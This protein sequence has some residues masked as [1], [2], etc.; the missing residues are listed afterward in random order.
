[1][2]SS[3][4]DSEFWDTDASDDS[5][6]AEA[7]PGPAPLILDLPD[8]P[9]RRGLGFPG[10]TLDQPE[11][12]VKPSEADVDLAGLWGDHNLEV[13]DAPPSLPDAEPVRDP[14]PPVPTVDLGRP[15]ADTGPQRSGPLVVD[16]PP[17][18]PSVSDVADR[19]APLVLDLPSARSGAVADR[20]A[21]MVM[22]LPPSVSDAAGRSAPMVLD[23]PPTRSASA[24]GN[25]GFDPMVLDLPRTR[26]DTGV[27]ASAPVI[28]DLPP[29][30]SDTAPDPSPIPQP[31]VFDSPEVAVDPPG[32]SADSVEVADS[33]DEEIADSAPEP[34]N[35]TPP[36]PPSDSPSAPLDLNRPERGSEAL[37][38]GFDRVQRRRSEKPVAVAAAAAA[39]MAERRSSAALT[40]A[41]T[42]TAPPSRTRRSSGIGPIVPADPWWT[43]AREGRAPKF[44]AAGV[45]AAAVVVGGVFVIR[46]G[47]GSPGGDSS[48][49]VSAPPAAAPAPKSTAK[50]PGAISS[51]PAPPASPAPNA[52][53]AGPLVPGKPTGIATAVRPPSS[54][55]GTTSSAG[56]GESQ[57]PA[58]SE[59]DQVVDDG[60]SVPADGQASTGR[61]P[62][63]LSTIFPPAPSPPPPVP[64]QPPHAEPPPSVTPPPLP[65]PHSDVCRNVPPAALADCL[66]AIG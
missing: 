30:N 36:E 26:S 8:A 24:A 25:P 64:T 55:A 65:P 23:L 17:A 46:A 59:P 11:P 4:P 41:G 22:D 18:P 19:S 35:T 29:I 27:D 53:P 60:S 21:P 56:R 52:G 66:A 40:E 28:L 12:V 49:L 45:A 7:R 13:A 43:R 33:A 34:V 5:E 47:S 54:P 57:T 9:D 6:A 14:D 3:N 50:I 39:A 44:V 2:S 16:L 58:A 31:I 42:R 32:L 62:V 15:V 1:M 10:P 37:K 20:S 48:R 51:P 61:P 38:P 63:D